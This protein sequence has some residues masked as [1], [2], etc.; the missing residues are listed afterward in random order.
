MPKAASLPASR[1]S[2][3]WTKSLLTALN[4]LGL[5][6]ILLVIVSPIL[7]M[8]Q[9]SFR[10][11]DVLFVLPP[12]LT[13]GWT[14]ANYADLA[15]TDFPT[16]VFNSFK[17]AT[18]TTALALVIGVPAAYSL[19][20]TRFRRQGLITFW[21]LGTRMALPIVFALPMFVL[22][23]RLG[24]GNSHPGLVIV[25][26]TF[27]LPMII[28]TMRPFFDGIPRDLEESAWVDGA[29]P[30]QAFLQVTLPCSGNGLAAVGV[31][32]FIQAWIEFFFALVFTRGANMTAP[33]AIVN[34]MSYA[35]TEWGKITAAGTAIML[36]VILFA[37]FTHK[38]L[39]KGFTAGAVKG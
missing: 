11:P 27:I 32:C 34:F 31:L 24:L 12:P 8:V 19:S 25:Y 22:F 9:M 38:Y 26:M 7:W 33:V 15:Q 2:K 23:Q 16:N 37:I 36:P 1:A 18:A 10:T 13:Q 21:V 30:L 17:V 35:G 4:V 14:L 28:W 3:K 29:S 5:L 39:I 6:G 20:R